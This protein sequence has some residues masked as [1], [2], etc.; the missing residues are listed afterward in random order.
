MAARTIRCPFLEDRG[1]ALKV[2]FG[3]Q[4]LWNETAQF[5]GTTYREQ[6][7]QEK[8]TVVD[9]YDVGYDL[10]ASLANPPPYD[11]SFLGP[12]PLIE[13][14][15]LDR[16]RVVTSRK[17]SQAE[18]Y[19]EIDIES[20]L[21]EFWLGPGLT[22]RPADNTE[23]YFISSIS[24]TR[25]TMDIDRSERFT[26]THAGGSSDVLNSWHNSTCE[27]EWSFGAGIQVG[28][29]VDLTDDWFAG[30]FGT[31]DWVDEANVDIG[32]NSISVDPTGY[33]VGFEIGTRL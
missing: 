6:I 22:V 8:Y 2:C 28:A 23:I 24:L 16:E 29:T 18:N 11:G 19:V 33:T 26:V 10:T 14:E 31:Y 25:V 15:P 1:S 21:C 4:A 12:G 7:T 13:G 32:P 9:T 27:S 30:A 20:D 5:K 17:V 3:A